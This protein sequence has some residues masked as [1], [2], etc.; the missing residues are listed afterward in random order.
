MTEQKKKLAPTHPG[1]LLR[2]EVMPAAKLTQEKLAILLGVSRRTVNEIVT[3]KRSL[4]A[5]MAHRRW[6][7]LSQLQCPREA[8]VG[9]GP[10][11]RH[12]PR[13][14]QLADRAD[15]S[16]KPVTRPSLSCSAASANLVP[17][18]DS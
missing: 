4:S 13:R 5:D 18:S 3:E 2:D 14:R 15:D 8:S 10:G 17:A 6:P 16:R 7:A 9:D 12:C 1:E 11:Q